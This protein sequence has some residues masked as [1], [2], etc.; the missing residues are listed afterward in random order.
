MAPGIDAAEAVEVGQQVTKNEQDAPWEETPKPRERL[1]ASPRRAT[2]PRADPQND[3]KPVSDGENAELI[4][5]GVWP[6]C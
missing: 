4:A 2:S 5:L 3:A 1:A 6:R